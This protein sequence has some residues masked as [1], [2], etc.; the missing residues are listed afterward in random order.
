MNLEALCN[1]LKELRVHNNLTQGELSERTGVT[2]AK[3]SKIESVSNFNM[4]IFLTLF[5]FYKE[6]IA[7]TQLVAFL[8]DVED[9][10]TE[11]IKEKIVLIQEKHNEDFNKL[12]KDI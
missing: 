9:D 7:P 5:S 2:Q 12:L 11:I 1:K 4:D 3:I 6:E 8:F 10:Y